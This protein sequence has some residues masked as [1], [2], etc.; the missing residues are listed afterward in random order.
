MLDLMA[1]MLK[2]A[3]PLHAEALK[4]QV[5]VHAFCVSILVFI[6]ASRGMPSVPEAARIFFRGE[7]QSGP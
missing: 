4:R 1:V 3:G 2:V 6:L 7:C 5:F